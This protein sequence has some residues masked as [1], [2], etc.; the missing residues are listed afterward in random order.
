MTVSA[1]WAMKSTLAKILFRGHLRIQQTIAKSS[2]EVEC[3][4]MGVTIA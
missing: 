4:F 2:I 1:P 3:K